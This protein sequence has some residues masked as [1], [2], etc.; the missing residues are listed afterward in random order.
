ME[1]L[2]LYIHIEFLK[3][4][5]KNLVDGFTEGK[6]KWRKKIKKA[7]ENIQNEACSDKDM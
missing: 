4:Q 7:E 5:M 2:I 3:I 6:Y 1:N